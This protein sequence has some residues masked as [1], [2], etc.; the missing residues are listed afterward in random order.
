MAAILF[1]NRDFISYFVGT[2]AL[3]EGKNGD[4]S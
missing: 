3:N 2:N 4:T 1:A